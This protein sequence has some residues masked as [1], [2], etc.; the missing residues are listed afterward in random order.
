MKKQIPN[1]ITLLNL[2]FG[3]VAVTALLNGYFSI[4]LYCFLF[5][6][7][8][9]FADGFVA[10]LLNV[11]SPVGK[12]LDSLADM[13]SFGVVPG[14]IFYV[15]LGGNEMTLS[16][17]FSLQSLLPLAG[18]IFSMLA[19]LRLARFNLD[20]RQSV[21]FI[22]LNTPTATGFVI[23]LLM[24]YQNDTFGLGEFV[25]QKIFLLP[26]ILFLSYLMISEFPMFSGKF[27]GSK[28][29]GNEYRIIFVLA[30]LTEFFL[31]GYAA[32]ATIVLTYMVLS[33]I[34]FFTKK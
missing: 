26:I 22:G 28:W 15:L 7:A 10:R 34:A 9:D 2:F 21:D 14:M 31:F 23:G 1:I 13:V 3:C 19:C 25:A 27:K 8:M 29:K 18:F 4:V 16:Q 11:S 6:I 12:E 20:T 5:S 30:A 32:F 24:I 17:G 33:A